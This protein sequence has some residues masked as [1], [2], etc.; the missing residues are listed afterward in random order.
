MEGVPPGRRA[1]RALSAAVPSQ[2]LEPRGRRERLR[3]AR[4]AGWALGAQAPVRCENQPLCG[5][6]TNRCA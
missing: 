6:R 5:A 3:I 1:A 2:R 4:A